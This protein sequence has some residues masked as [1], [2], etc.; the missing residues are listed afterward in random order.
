MKSHH[1]SKNVRHEWGFIPDEGVP[2][3]ELLPVGE[4]ADD[5][6]D[7]LEGDGGVGRARVVHDRRAQVERSPYRFLQ[8]QFADI[9][10]LVCKFKFRMN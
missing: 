8:E 2:E 3:V 7:A 4:R 9:I 6:V 5:D 1:L 10:C